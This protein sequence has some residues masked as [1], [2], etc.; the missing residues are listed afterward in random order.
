VVV[1]YSS[2]GIYF[3]GIRNRSVKIEESVIRYNSDYGIR[4]DR[5]NNGNNNDRASISVINS[6]IVDN[7]R[8]GVYGNYDYGKWEITGCKILRNGEYGIHLRGTRKQVINNNEINGNKNGLFAYENSDGVRTISGNNISE[9]K[10]DGLYVGHN[11]CDNELVQIVDNKINSNGGSGVNL[12]NSIYGNFEFKGNE[13]KNN[14][15][16]GFYHWDT[17][18]KNVTVEDNVI[19]G[20]EGQGMRFDRIYGNVLI[21]NNVG[22]YGQNASLAPHCPQ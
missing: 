12:G 4:G 9:N 1:E 6:Q 14:K 2:Y 19:E 17:L 13:I 10:S 3:A 15:G 5:D 11:C 21:Q 7:Y 16:N 22:K 8:Q 18:R 20:N